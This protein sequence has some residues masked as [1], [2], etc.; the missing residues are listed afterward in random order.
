MENTTETRNAN[1]ITYKVSGSETNSVAEYRRNDA[2]T[3]RFNVLKINGRNTGTREEC[4]AA[5]DNRIGFEPDEAANAE[6]YAGI[7]N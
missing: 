3:R 5:V 7:R 6:F 2:K 4:R 1:G